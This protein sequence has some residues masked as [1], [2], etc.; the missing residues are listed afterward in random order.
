MSFEDLAFDAGSFSGRVR[1]FPLPNMVLFPH[2]LQPLHIFEPR[3]RA[4]LE[5]ALAGDR[6]IAMAVLDSGWEDD[7]DG[8][9]PLKPTACLGRIV[10]HQQTDDGKYNLLLAGLKRLEIVR[11]LPPTKLF[12]EAQ[13]A[14]LE[15]RYVPHGVE[16]R[17]DLQ[18]RLIEAFEKALPKMPEVHQQLKE[19]L[20][21]E[22]SLGMLTDLVAYTLQLPLDAKCELLACLD[23]ERRCEILLERL[24]SGGAT[25]GGSSPPRGLKWPP[26]FSQ[27]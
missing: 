1:L 13:V 17:T 11:E 12:R 26:D 14:V 8:R 4:L 27:N 2:V 18:R 10:T 21:S 20:G 22:V 15:D 16:Q 25:F 6:L 19:L 24:G 23:V 5:E 9:P 3:Y 7:Y